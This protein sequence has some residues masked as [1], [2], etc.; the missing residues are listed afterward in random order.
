M[1]HI[2][3]LGKTL[4]LFRSAKQPG[5][6]TLI[7]SIQFLSSVPGGSETL[8]ERTNLGNEM[9]RIGPDVWVLDWNERGAVRRYATRS[10]GSEPAQMGRDL[11]VN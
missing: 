4:P 9:R 11:S 7:R 10:A 3:E 1:S 8:V 6:Y 2:P 5:L